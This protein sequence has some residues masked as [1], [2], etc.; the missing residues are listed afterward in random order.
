MISLRHM[1]AHHFVERLAYLREHGAVGRGRPM[2]GVAPLP[3][4]H[5]AE[6]RRK[7]PRPPTP[8]ILLART[9]A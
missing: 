9:R 3:P 8:A 7:P 4:E 5:P 2:G 1:S 6:Y